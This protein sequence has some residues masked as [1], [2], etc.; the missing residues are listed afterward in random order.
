M[1]V[2]FFIGSFLYFTHA[3]AHE[4]YVLNHDEIATDIA[5]PPLNLFAVAV[6]QES[7]FFTSAFVGLL[8]VILILG[9]SLSRKVEKAIDPFL[10]KIKP[11]SSYVAQITIGCALLA[12]AY[13]GALFGVELPLNHLF[14]GYD[15]LA[16]IILYISAFSILFGIYPRIG[17]LC[18]V[19]IYLAAVCSGQGLYMISYL[20]YF[21][22]G[23]IIFFLGAG[24]SFLG[25][26]RKGDSA[27]MKALRKRSHFILRI[28]FSTSLIYAAFY[29][30]F[31]HGA[32]ALDTVMKYH[33]T[34]YFHFAPLFIVLGAFL[35]ELSIGLFYLIG[36]EI[37]FVS[38]FFLT[39]LTL[40]LVFFGEA[41]WPH[42]ILIGTAIGLFVHGYDEYTLERRWYIQG[43]REPVL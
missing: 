11:Y 42:I 31:I 8:L 24:Y 41:V 12:S 5:Q 27:F 26:T 28:C 30:K 33:L 15:V 35:V 34:N 36:F 19:A 17:G 14:G 9:I 10:F 4:V 25:S 21:A 2:L 7:L 29:A 39:F 23:G 40:S 43:K 22:E 37:R 6:S 1:F 13:Y 16:T 18:A 32:L 3:S 38:L 20:T